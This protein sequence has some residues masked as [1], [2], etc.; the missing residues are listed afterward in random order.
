[1]RSV[2]EWDGSE[3]R[4]SKFGRCYDGLALLLLMWPATG[5]MWLLGSTR[6]WGY[7]PGLIFSLAGSLLVLAR[8][9]VFPRTPGWWIPPGFWVWLALTAYVIFQVPWALV[10]CTA[11]WEALRWT[12]LLAAAFAW[13]Q[14]GGRAHRWKWLLGILFLAVTF[15]SLYA[16]VQHVNHSGR[17]LWTD[18][19]EQY[20]LRA[21]GT[22]RCPNHFADML[23]MLFPL[24]LVLIFL[25]EAGFPLRLMAVYFSVVSAPALYWTQS[26]S[27]WL[28]AAGGVGVALLLLAWRKSRAGL[29]AALVAL[30]LL[31]GAFGWVAWQTLPAVRDRFGAVLADPEEAGGIRM[32]MWRDAPEMFRNRPAFGF[33]GGSF[34]W[35]YPPHQRHVENH[36]TWDYLHNEY[37]QMALE[38]GAAGLGLALIGLLATTWGIVRGVLRA[39]SR[40]GAVLLAGAGGAL[41]GG[42]IHACFD[43]NFHIFPNPH[44]LVWIGG[45]AWGVWAVHEQGDG[46]V[47]GRRRSFRR[48]AS[49]LGAGLCAGCAWLALSG[50]LSYVW[51]LKAEIARTRMD[52]VAAATAYEKAIRWDGWN[53]RPHL[54]LGHLK[55]VQ[56]VW[57]RD[58]DPAVE[59]EGKLQLTGQAAEHYQQALRRNPGDMAAVLGLARTFRAAGD[60]EAALEQFRRA[61]SYQHRHV[62][63]REQFG[64]QLRQMGRDDE[65]LE[66]F[67][68]NVADGVASDVSDL[69]IRAL[70]RK[71]AKAA[72]VAPSP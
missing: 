10:P 71:Q 25:P 60:S 44:A 32:A 50:G 31:A 51:N 9:L 35:A 20:G 28:G 30:P 43:F 17:V 36:L 67:R 5:G 72:A 13:T 26:R 29:L 2:G 55:S 46:P 38:Y 14:M 23:A 42:L 63:Y 22:Y 41:G 69:N 11:R 52:S 66:V 59:R 56:A 1:M 47:N 12:C 64:I 48:V 61:A 62:F 15:V 19:P 54:G 34:V 24:A 49:V 45:I 57:F 40:E 65:A 7:A 16:L 39:R 8:P 27:G 18:R 4:S 58:P 53:W 70:E 68:R 37:I 33:G 6:T 3:G 21:S